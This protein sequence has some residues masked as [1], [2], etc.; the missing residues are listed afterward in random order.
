MIEDVERA[1]ELGCGMLMEA[2]LLANHLEVCRHVAPEIAVLICRLQQLTTG[3]CSDPL[4]T[5]RPAEHVAVN[6]GGGV[7]DSLQAVDNNNIQAV[8]TDALVYLFRA[9]QQ[10][11][12][13][14]TTSRKLRCE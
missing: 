1:C 8:E 7:T 3:T 4:L 14:L 6:T 5:T 11:L 12:K 9:Q 2:E 13:S 10:T